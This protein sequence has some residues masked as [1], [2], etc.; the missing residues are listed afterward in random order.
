ME[1]RL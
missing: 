1:E